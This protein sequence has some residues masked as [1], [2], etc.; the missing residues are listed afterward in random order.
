MLWIVTGI[1]LENFPDTAEWCTV[2][3]SV[4]GMLRS[5]LPDTDDMFTLAGTVLLSI[6]VL[7]DTELTS[8]VLNSPDAFVLPDVVFMSMTDA[9]VSVALKEPETPV[10]SSLFVLM[11]SKF[12]VPDVV[13]ILSVSE[14]RF[15]A[16]IVADTE[17]KLIDDALKSSMIIVPDV[18]LTVNFVM[19]SLRLR[20]TRT[21]RFFRGMFPLN[22]PDSRN[23][24]V[25][26]PPAVFTR[27]F[28]LSLSSRWAYSVMRISLPSCG[29]T[30]ISPDTQLM[31]SV[32]MFAG[33]SDWVP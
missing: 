5:I 23:D 2:I 32:L 6:V 21:S 28:S 25:N 4:F 16:V 29:V 8:T 7:P 18:V 33:S 31:F 3:D 22:V 9:I 11:L 10:L 17:L 1:S 30:V 14:V 13:D 19:S 20:G 12:I 15:D 27:I 26:V 24:T